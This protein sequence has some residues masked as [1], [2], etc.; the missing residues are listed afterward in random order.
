M[1]RLAREGK[2]VLRLKGGD[3]FMFGRGG[4]EIEALAEHGIPFQVCPGITAAAGAS[5]YAGIPLT[6][7]DHAQACVF[8]TGHGKDGHVDLD[9]KSLVQPNQ[10]VAVYMGLRNLESLTQEFIVRGA[11]ADMP[12]AI[13]DNATRPSQ[14]V[15]VGTLRSLAAQAR[16]AELRGPSIL[17]VGTVVTL[18]GKLHAEAAREL[19]TSPPRRRSTQR[20]RRPPRSAKPDRRANL[21]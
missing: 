3:P 9:W 19:R 7:R 2:R 13:V 20:S 18:R 4:E 6:H 11:R 5:A 15:I 14:R 21:C 16:A 1:V 12:A 10:T 8:V 17:I